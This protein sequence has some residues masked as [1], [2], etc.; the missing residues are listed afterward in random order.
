[1]KD[2]CK[3]CKDQARATPTVHLCGIA[4]S[5]AATT[6]ALSDLYPGTGPQSL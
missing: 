4:T 5:S 6:R 3:D 1:M 2:S